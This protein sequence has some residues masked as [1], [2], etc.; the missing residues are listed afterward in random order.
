MIRSGLK[1]MRDFVFGLK[2]QPYCG[3]QIE[4]ILFKRVDEGR[5]AICCKL[6]RRSALHAQWF[7]QDQ[8]PELA[9]GLQRAYTQH[10]GDSQERVFMPLRVADATERQR[11]EL[12]APDPVSV[13]DLVECGVTH[14]NRQRYQEVRAQLPPFAQQDF[15]QLLLLVQWSASDFSLERALYVPNVVELLLQLAQPQPAAPG[16]QYE[17]DPLVDAVVEVMGCCWGQRVSSCQI[18]T[19][20]GSKQLQKTIAGQR[21]VLV[22]HRAAGVMQNDQKRRQLLLNLAG[23]LVAEGRRPLVITKQGFLAQQIH[24]LEQRRVGVLEVCDDQVARAMAAD[25]AYDVLVWQYGAHNAELGRAAL[26]GRA[27]DV[28]VL[29]ET[30]R[31][32][33]GQFEFVRADYKVVLAAVRRQPEQNHGLLRF[34]NRELA[35]LCADSDR[36]AVECLA[37]YELGQLASC[38]RAEFLRALQ[39]EVDVQERAAQRASLSIAR[40]KFGTSNQFYEQMVGLSGGQRQTHLVLMID[41]TFEEKVRQ[42]LFIDQD[43]V[44]FKI[45]HD[46]R[47]GVTTMQDLKKVQTGKMT[48]QIYMG[49]VNYLVS[50]LL[51]LLWVCGPENGARLNPSR[52]EMVRMYLHSL[53]LTNAS[54]CLLVAPVEVAPHVADYCASLQRYHVLTELQQSPVDDRLT[55]Y[56]LSEAQ[57]QAYYVIAVKCGD[58]QLLSPAAL[59]ANILFPVVCGR[60]SDVM[61]DA[62]Y[63]AHKVSGHRIFQVCA[64]RTVEQHLLVYRQKF[65]YLMLQ[66]Q[67]EFYGQLAAHGAAERPFSRYGQILKMIDEKGFDGMNDADP[68]SFGAEPGRLDENA[69]SY[70]FFRFVRSILCSFMHTDMVLQAAFNDIFDVD[71]QKFNMR[72]YAAEVYGTQDQQYNIHGEPAIYDTPGLIE[73]D[74]QKSDRLAVDGCGVYYYTTQGDVKL[75]Q[76][77]AKPRLMQ[78]FAQIPQS[79]ITTQIAEA[80]QKLQL[81]TDQNV[82]N[83]HLR[84]FFLRINSQ[85]DTQKYIKSYSYQDA[86]AKKKKNRSYIETPVICSKEGRARANVGL[87]SDLVDPPPHR[88]TV[89]GKCSERE[90]VYGPRCDL[91]GQP[92]KQSYDLTQVEQIG[93]AGRGCCLCLKQL[94][95]ERELAAGAAEHLTNSGLNA[96]SY[97]GGN[98]LEGLYVTP[99]DHL[100]DEDYELIRGILDKPEFRPRFVKA[101]AAAASLLN[102]VNPTFPV[103]IRRRVAVSNELA[104]H[105]HAWLQLYM[106]ELVR[107][108]RGVVGLE[109]LISVAVP[110]DLFE[111]YCQPWSYDPELIGSPINAVGLQQYAIKYVYYLLK[112]AEAWDLRGNYDYFQFHYQYYLF[113]GQLTL[114]QKYGQLAKAGY[115]KLLVNSLRSFPALSSCSVFSNSTVPNDSYIL[116]AVLTNVHALVPD[117]PKVR[118]SAST[119]RLRSQLQLQPFVVQRAYRYHV[120]NAAL[121]N[122]LYYVLSEQDQRALLE[123]YDRQGEDGRLDLVRQLVNVKYNP[124]QVLAG[125]YDAN[126]FANERAIDR[127]VYP[128]GKQIDFI[129]G[130]V[131]RENVVKLQLQTNPAAQ[132]P[133]VP[134][135]QSQPLHAQPV[136]NTQS[137][138]AQPPVYNTAQY[139]PRGAH[140]YPHVQPSNISAQKILQQNQITINQQQMQQ[141]QKMQQQRSAQQQFGH[142]PQVHQ[143]GVYSPQKQNFVDEVVGI[144]LQGQ[145]KPAVA[146]VNDIVRRV[147]QHQAAKF[148]L[149]KQNLLYVPDVVVTK[150]V[151]DVFPRQIGIANPQV[152]GQIEAKTYCSFADYIVQL[153]DQ[154]TQF[155]QQQVNP[156]KFWSLSDEK[157]REIKKYT[158]NSQIK[159]AQFG[160]LNICQEWVLKHLL[161]MDCD[162][163]EKKVVYFAQDPVIGLGISDPGLYRQG[164]EKFSC[165]IDRQC[166]GLAKEQIERTYVD[167]CKEIQKHDKNITNNIIRQVATFSVGLGSS[168]LEVFSHYTKSFSCDLLELFAKVMQLFSFCRY[169]GVKFPYEVPDVTDTPANFSRTYE[170]MEIM[171]LMYIKIEQIEYFIWLSR[172]QKLAKDKND[173]ASLKLASDF[174]QLCMLNVKEDPLIQTKVQK[175]PA[176]S[177]RLAKLLADAACT[178]NINRQILQIDALFSTFIQ[179]N[180]QYFDKNRQYPLPCF[181]VNDSNLTT[182]RDAWIVSACYKIV[183][184]TIFGQKYVVVEDIC[185]QKFGAQADE[186]LDGIRELYQKILNLWSRFQDYLLIFLQLDVGSAGQV[187][188]LLRREPKTFQAHVDE[189][190]MKKIQIIRPSRIVESIDD[191]RASPLTQVLL[192]ARNAAPLA[193]YQPKHFYRTFAYFYEQLRVQQLPDFRAQSHEQFIEDFR[194]LG[195]RGLLCHPPQQPEAIDRRME[196]IKKGLLYER[197]LV[198]NPELLVQPGFHGPAAPAK[199]Y[200]PAA[201]PVPPDRPPPPL[202]QGL[203]PPGAVP[204]KQEEAAPPGG[205]HAQLTAEQIAIINAKPLAFYRESPQRVH[206][207][208]V[209]VLGRNGDMRVDRDTDADELAQFLFLQSSCQRSHTD[210]WGRLF[211]FLINVPPEP[212]EV[213]QKHVRQRYEKIQQIVSARL[214]MRGDGQDC[215]ARLQQGM[216]RLTEGE[217]AEVNELTREYV[218]HNLDIAY[219]YAFRMRE[220]VIKNPDSNVN[221]YK[222]NIHGA[223][224]QMQVLNQRPLNAI[225]QDRSPVSKKKMNLATYF[226]L[227]QNA[228]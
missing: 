51:R 166:V 179:Q 16:A 208:I 123:L 163:K 57:V 195:A 52:Q 13:K 54:S 65:S 48:Y 200:P 104:A 197:N 157:N 83:Q 160:K 40:I 78:Y 153:C 158:D 35:R 220:D 37:F 1:T 180:N 128:D 131:A 23:R 171:R 46:D 47:K 58:T 178:E 221:Q 194:T 74:V 141:H 135:P 216:D 33:A 115:I 214:S 19:V 9:L 177:E 77:A 111:I 224:K 134:L 102:Q 105:G 72:Y 42:R 67:E 143:P 29:D 226:F 79:T 167:L 113:S 88:P 154:Y 215:F 211:S 82:A 223:L 152:I 85:V 205:Q 66:E 80:L 17:P 22:D 138:A 155:S 39:P 114:S 181:G 6:A 176:V 213:S 81:N 189:K 43:H 100:A 96:I 217:R 24:D 203:V 20:R 14:Y 38:E 2:V 94:M 21:A 36:A 53:E 162:L 199:P 5:Q 225:I 212:V 129:A 170:H 140:G 173:E 25:G 148:Y 56:V 84:N 185:R 130:Q 64:T 196:L 44:L 32:P 169:N 186:V 133:G 86:T 116:M 4:Q 89:C 222:A 182:L 175:Y 15:E 75:G 112:R 219:Y 125:L 3:Q 95:P 60:C 63:H 121:H 126:Q 228:R 144:M 117:F 209:D 41:Q 124:I 156:Y 101:V 90:L 184:L 68:Q 49:A 127:H 151:C 142:P 149:A 174:N 183:F 12:P 137:L 69:K 207:F 108:Q 150:K 218:V 55:V 168:P 146:S 191:V 147:M 165:H 11:A 26:E 204:V 187:S 202:P 45:L 34:V 91:C 188:K 190:I 103:P 119:M 99:L 50:S 27:V 201:L 73:V 139:Q 59:P 28:V 109:R 172:I 120:R 198:F 87:F 193:Q 62:V 92:M 30:V 132:A 210:E 18:A 106:N 161:L 61:L 110:Y 31:T 136:K 97:V 10:S 159:L 145:Q 118:I 71:D 98:R 8:V 227:A 192:R 122:Q 7:Y 70:Y 107:G 206:Q 164:A 93:R 76:G